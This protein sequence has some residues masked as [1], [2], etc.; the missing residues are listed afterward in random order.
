[1]RSPIQIFRDYT[2]VKKFK[3]AILVALRSAPVGT[4][5]RDESDPCWKIAMMQLLR[6]HPHW[7]V[8]YQPTG[9]TTVSIYRAPDFECAVSA[10]ERVLL[11]E[12]G[13]IATSDTA[14][15]LDPD[16][17]A[18]APYSVE[19]EPPGPGGVRGIRHED[20]PRIVPATR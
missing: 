10:G 18:P 8:V 19:D 1:M 3:K 17:P 12:G 4:G 13:R 9:S 11:G 5:V 15:L 14:H 20:H 7:F 2:R 6:E 16:Y